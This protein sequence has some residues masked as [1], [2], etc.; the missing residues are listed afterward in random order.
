MAGGIAAVPGIP[1]ISTV[2]IGGTFEAGDIFSIT[3]DGRVFGGT[4][5]TAGVPATVALPH[6]SKTYAVAGPNLFG[7]AI[8]DPTEWNG[9]TGSFVTDMSSENSGSER[10]TALGIH[11]NKLAIYSRTT[12]Q[13]WLVDSD[14]ANNEQVQVLEN[15]GTL[16]AKSIQSYGDADQFFLAD[17][18]VRSLRVRINSDNAALSDI[19]SPI[20]PL[21]IAAIKAAGGNATKACSVIDP[22]DGRY[23][24][25]IGAVTYAFSFFPNAKVSAWSTWETGLSITNFAIVGQR[26]YARAGNVIYLLGG[27]DNDEWAAQAMEV[28]LP[29]LSAR[30]IA[31][32]KHFTG[33]DIACDGEFDVYLGTDPNQPDVDEPIAKI[34]KSTFGLGRVPVDGQAEM[35]SLRFVSK[36]GQYGRIANAVVHYEPLEAA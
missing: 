15:I 2:N 20:D 26:V 32:L 31:T 5:G 22:I 18:G 1:Q 6:R 10:L 21:I 33:V 27:D 17:T 30:Q 29:F 23:L 24:L 9:G 28:K 7:S 13:I 34:T 12:I 11:E 14:P 8:D 19:G 25:Q 16:A 4:A 35:F 3:L 36:A